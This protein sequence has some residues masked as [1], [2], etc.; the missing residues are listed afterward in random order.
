[1]THS[2]HSFS[3]NAV[4][5]GFGGFFFPL[6]VGCDAESDPHLENSP[7]TEQEQ[8]GGTPKVTLPHKRGSV[9]MC[10]GVFGVGLSPG[11]SRN[12]ERRAEREDLSVPVEEN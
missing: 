11:N 9:Q 8:L 2:L 5:F 3:R 7:C 10:F 1:M 4:K 12:G 6:S